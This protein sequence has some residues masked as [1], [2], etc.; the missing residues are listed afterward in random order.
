MAPTVAWKLLHSMVT[1]WRGD[2]LT[3]SQR[4][5]LDTQGRSGSSGTSRSMLTVTPS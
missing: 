5:W 3:A 1:R 2:D 4:P